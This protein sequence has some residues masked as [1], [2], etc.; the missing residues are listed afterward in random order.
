MSLIA[1]KKKEELLRKEKAL[2]DSRFEVSTKWEKMKRAQVQ[3]V[4]EFSVQK[5]KRKS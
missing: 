5:I 2:R 4:D 3:Q 1:K